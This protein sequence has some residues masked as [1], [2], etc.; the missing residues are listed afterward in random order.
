[1]NTILV[2]A[3]GGITTSSQRTQ[4]IRHVAEFPDHLGIVEIARGG[5]TSAAGCD[6]TKVTFLAR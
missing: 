3:D 4:I 1:M 2:P 5:N 6:G